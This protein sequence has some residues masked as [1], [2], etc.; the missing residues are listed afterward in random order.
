MNNTTDKDYSPFDHGTQTKEPNDKF[1]K[2]P[3]E[4]EVLLSDS[5]KFEPIGDIINSEIY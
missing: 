5:E 4:I 1:Y 2:S 3:E